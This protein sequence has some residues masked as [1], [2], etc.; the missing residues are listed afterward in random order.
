MPLIR[1]F[2]TQYQPFQR[3]SQRTKQG[4]FRQF[5]RG[6]VCSQFAFLTRSCIWFLSVSKSD[7][8]YTKE[9]WRK[10]RRTKSMWHMTPRAGKGLCDCGWGRRQR[11][12]TAQSAFVPFFNSLIWDPDSSH[13]LPP[14]LKIPV[15]SSFIILCNPQRQHTVWFPACQEWIG[16]NLQKK[17]DNHW[18]IWHCYTQVAALCSYPVCAQYPY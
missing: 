17:S 11:R 12:I 1:S 6:S 7:F 14:A 18:K 16:Q 10:R 3:N 8:W 4:F 9:A 5:W 13:S 2:Q 15:F